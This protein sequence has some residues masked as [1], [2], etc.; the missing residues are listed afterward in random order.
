MHQLWWVTGGVLE[1]L[2][3]GGLENSI[4]VKRL[5]GQVDMTQADKGTEAISW[6]SFKS[7]L[8]SS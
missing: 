3:D 2:Q 6:G 8:R 5:L 4:A 1:S 7:L